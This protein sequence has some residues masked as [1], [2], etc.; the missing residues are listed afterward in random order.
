MALDAA[1]GEP[2]WLWSRLAH[3]AI[4]MG[5][6]IDLCDK[7]FNRGNARKSSGL[8]VTATLVALAVALGLVIQSLPL[9]WLWSLILTAILLAQ[10]SLVDHVAAV[11]TAL[12]ASLAQGRRSVSMIVGRDPDALDEPAVARAA[13]ES[14]AENLSDGVIAPAFWFLVAG[15]PGIFLYKIINTADSMIGH[16]TPRHEDFGWAAA[17]LDDLLNYLPARLTALLIA[18]TTRPSTFKTAVRDGPKHRSVNAGWPEAAMAAALGLSLSGPR[19]Y[20]GE[21][22][23]DPEM[24]PSGTRNATPGDI[25]ATVAVLWRVWVAALAIIAILAL[26]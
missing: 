19:A 17:R 8:A 4:L 2:K 13:I 10:R 12:R 23:N 15:L 14:A 25:T 6:L 9:G 18:L 11:A 20:G 16:R 5:R 7:R 22:T 24:N 1:F 3:P 26:L 21:M